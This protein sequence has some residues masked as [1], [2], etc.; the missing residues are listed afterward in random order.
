MIRIR[1]C[2]GFVAVVAL[3]VG[4]SAVSAGIEDGL[5][6]YWNFDQ[7][8][9]QYNDQVGTVH[10]RERGGVG[11]N[12]A[13][14][15]TKT[16]GA[17]IGASVHNTANHGTGSEWLTSNGAQGTYN[18]VDAMTISYWVKEDNN[19]TPVNSPGTP[20]IRSYFHRSSYSGDSVFGDFSTFSSYNR[21]AYKEPAKNN[22]YWFN[23]GSGSTSI[24]FGTGEGIDFKTDEDVWYHRVLRLE[25]DGTVHDNLASVTQTMAD[26]ESATRTWA[27][28]M[29]DPAN[30]STDPYTGLSASNGSSW[31]LTALGGYDEP[32]TWMDE[33]GIWNRSLSD[34]EVQQL[35]QAGQNGTALPDI[36]EPA[37]LGLLAVMGL[38]AL[39]RRRA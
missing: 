34:A 14:I 5:Q 37:T 9:P 11:T 31:Q 24:G 26:G 28:E 29:A 6:S 21:Q 36:P 18:I 17:L 4:A 25:S 7:A 19:D 39:K 10:L 16:S 3:V 13:E 2:T 22:W 33:W 35:H 1:L 38:L 8:G 32:G 15:S 27:D 30:G 20:H 12:V 23:K